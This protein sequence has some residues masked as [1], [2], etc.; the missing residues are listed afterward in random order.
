MGIF[1]DV[2]G[3]TRPGQANGTG[4]VTANMLEEFAGSVKG[5]LE[6]VSVLAPRIPIR[7]VRGT[8]TI[9]NFAVG[10]STLVRLEP[11][12][13]PNGTPTKFGKSSLTIDTVTLARGITPL[14]EAFQVSYDARAEIGKEHGKEH[15]KQFD[16]AFFIQAI[17][18]GELTA[19]KFGLT[20]AGHTGGSQQVL[21][22]ANDHLDPAMLYQG[23]VDLI[24]QMRI[25]DV[26]PVSDGVMLGIS[27]TDFATLSMAEL[28]INSEYVTA[29]G[30]RIPQMVLKAHGVPVVP[31]NNFVGGTTV[32]GHLLST[33]ANSNAY[34]GDFTKVVAVA[35]APE[36]LLAGET[37]SLTPEVFWDKV[38]KQWFIDSYRSFGVTP[39]VAAFAGVLKKP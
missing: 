22:G 5:T 8:N 16:Q 9:S 37:I 31:S 28:L 11:G 38:S 35:W 23:I 14:L 20:A 33:A 2:S 39:S 32:T 12:V 10:K 6:R 34:D 15:A 24:T 21:A 26:D 1:D 25:K 19:N 18:A 30:T 17:K 29:D 27:H 36:A 13:T 4:S 3:I 7:T